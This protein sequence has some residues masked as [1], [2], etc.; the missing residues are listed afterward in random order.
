MKPK[1]NTNQVQTTSMARRNFCALIFFG[2][3]CFYLVNIKICI[4]CLFCV[5]LFVNLLWHINFCIEGT[6]HGVFTFADLLLQAK[7]IEVSKFSSNVFIAFSSHLPIS[8]LFVEAGLCCGLLAFVNLSWVLTFV[9]A[10]LVLYIRNVKFFL[11]THHTCWTMK[12][13]DQDVPL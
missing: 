9:K 13:W 3:V 6:C 7:L 2:K 4:E 11:E 5:L 1:S 10:N 8:C 12:G